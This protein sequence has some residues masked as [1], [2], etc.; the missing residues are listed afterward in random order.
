MS[1]TTTVDWAAARQAVSRARPRLTAML[2]SATK[3]EAPALGEWD[4]T[5]VATHVSHAMDAIT[6]MTTGGGNLIADIEGLPVLSRVMLEGE[7]RRPLSDLADRID[8]S[9]TRFLAGMEAAAAGTG[10]TSHSWLIQGTEMPLS[11][12]TCHMLNE[13]TVHGRDIAMALGVPWPI[14]KGDAALILQGF[15]FPSLHTLG[16][17]MVVQEK[18]GDKRARFEVRLRGDGR[19]WAYFDHGDFSVEGSP[20]GKVDCKLSVDPEAFLLVAWGRISQWS[21]I[22]KGQLLASGKKP[23]LGLQLRAWLRNP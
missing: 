12:L 13:L 7:G 6:A 10:D 14:D 16:R 18:E 19:A 23:W 9:V 2:R 8:A 1:A 15:V 21:A 20:Q 22:P 4:V 3:P 17:A 5:Q 11:T